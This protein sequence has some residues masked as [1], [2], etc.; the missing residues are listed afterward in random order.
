MVAK[1]LG[2]GLPDRAEIILAYGAELETLG[3]RVVRDVF[4]RGS[5]HLGRVGDRLVAGGTYERGRGDVSIT[6]ERLKDLLRSVVVLGC[7]LTQP[8]LVPVE[9]GAADAPA[10]VLGIEEAH[11]LGD[12]RP[13][14][15]LIPPD[16][17]VSDRRTVDLGDEQIAVGSQRSRWS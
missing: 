12:P 6:A 3:K 13:V 9:Q 15:L 14:R 7:D 8:R 5:H 10:P 2:L 4:D 1:R 11:E 17:A 16:A